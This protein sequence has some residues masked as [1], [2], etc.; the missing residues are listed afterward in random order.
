[1]ERYYSTKGEVKIGIIKYL[2]NVEDEFPG[3]IIG[4]SKSPA[5]DN[6]FQVREDTDPHKR[7]HTE[8]RAVQFHRVVYQLLF[9]SSRARHGIHTTISLLTSRV[10]KPDED[11]WGKL[12]RCMKYLKGTKYMKLTLTVDTMSVIKWWVDLYHHTHMYCRGNTAAMISLGNMAAVSYSGKHK[13]N[14]KI[15]TESELISDDDMLV[16]MLCSLYF[17]QAQVY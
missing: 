3:P 16:K 12:V 14:T 8:T 13:L 9:V 7:Y 10:R 6:L 5:G 2:Q 4:T 17:I 15:L 1:M 11:D